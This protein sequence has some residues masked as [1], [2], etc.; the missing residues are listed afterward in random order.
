VDIEAQTADGETKK[1]SAEL[2]LVATGRGPVTAGL[3]AE[4]VGLA[5]RRFPT[6]AAAVFRFDGEGRPSFE[7]L[8]LPPRPA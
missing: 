3:G 5:M 2:L 8:V 4:E 1:L 6:S 7:R